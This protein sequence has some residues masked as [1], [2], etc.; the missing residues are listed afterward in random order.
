MLFPYTS[1]P[2]GNELILKLTKN[3]ASAFF[4]I[5]DFAWIASNQ[6]SQKNL[7]PEPICQH[8]FVFPGIHL[9]FPAYI[10]VSRNVFFTLPACIFHFEKATI[11]GTHSMFWYLFNVTCLVVNL[12][13]TFCLFWVLS[14]QKTKAL[15]PLLAFKHISYA[16]ENFRVLGQGILTWEG[17]AYNWVPVF[18]VFNWPLVK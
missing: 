6:K 17:S 10:C 7:I 1:F 15:V 9:C 2:A 5:S 13:L 16:M 12:Q 18:P 11:P 3:M 4:L 14:I 8:T